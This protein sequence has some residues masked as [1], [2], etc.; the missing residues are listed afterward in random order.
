MRI[1]LWE[2]G[3]VDIPNVITSRDM[4]TQQRQ[5]D[6]M[7]ASEG[8]SVVDH[9]VT[10]TWW[11]D[12]VWVLESTRSPV[13]ARAYLSFLVDPQSLSLRKTGAQ[14]WAVCVSAEG[15]AITPMG[16][17]A[18]PLRPNWEKQGRKALLEKIRSLRAGEQ[19]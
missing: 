4:T 3:S 5:I 18:V 17:D 9:Q 13:G 16:T 8:W 6:E 7:L 12:E 2:H 19:R 11:L 14:V 10:P 15:P 1:G